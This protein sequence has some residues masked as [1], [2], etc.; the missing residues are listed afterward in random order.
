[1]ETFRKKERRVPKRIFAIASVEQGWKSGRKGHCKTEKENT[2]EEEKRKNR[3]Q[4]NRLC[5]ID[6]Q[7]STIIRPVFRSQMGGEAKNS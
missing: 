6:Q 7:S 4:K 5:R 1:L 2:L 3:R